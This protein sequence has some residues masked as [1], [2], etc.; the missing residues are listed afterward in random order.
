MSQVARDPIEQ[1]QVN[2]SAI[3]GHVAST[4]LEAH[5]DRSIDFVIEPGLIALGDAGLLEIVLTNLFDN[6]VK[7]TRP[8]AAARIVFGM[9]RHNGQAAYYVQDNGVGFEARYTSTLFGAFRRLHK[10]AEFPGTGIGLA[11]VK[12]VIHRHG[13]EVWAKSEPDRG[14]TFGF[15][16]GEQHE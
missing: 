1:Q 11:T 10:A 14:A 15:T 7:F 9:T 13:G 16:L 2:L 5:P 12:R 8:R 4:I 3:A 6:A